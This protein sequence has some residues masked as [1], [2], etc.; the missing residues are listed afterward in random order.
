MRRT[1]P[2]LRIVG[3]TLLIAVAVGFHA[4]PR[5]SAGQPPSPPPG[6]PGPA[7]AWV[8]APRSGPL[9]APLAG[10]GVVAPGCLYRSAQPTER[11]YTWLSE[12]GVRSIVSLRRERDHGAE[13]G[14][15]A[16][17]GCRQRGFR[18]LHLPIRDNDP[19]TDD[20]ARAFL[21]FV[22]EPAHW[23][24]LVHCE[25]G[26]GRA[27]TMAALARYAIDGW[28]MSRALREA[29]SYR[30]FGLRLYGAQR[31]WLNRWQERFPP[32]EYHPS[33]PLP[34]WPPAEGPLPAERPF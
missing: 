23:P 21:E 1:L 6:L 10:F 32:G 8:T 28:P 31:R 16:K 11:D 14:T 26:M 24:V 5:A 30:T 34:P 2:S 13:P 17:R 7:T 25:H 27:G 9:H 4:L 18:Y 33:R 12:Q 29:R 15:R 20:Q 3:P 22:R 19:P